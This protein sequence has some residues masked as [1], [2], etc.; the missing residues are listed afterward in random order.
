M[1]A[2]I[3][4]HGWTPQIGE[5]R[6]RG[7]VWM[8]IGRSS[9]QDSQFLVLVQVHGYA[10]RKWA[11]F[12]CGGSRSLAVVVIGTMH[13]ISPRLFWRR[14]QLT[15]PFSSTGGYIVVALAM[16]SNDVFYQGLDVC[17]LLSASMV[18]ADFGLW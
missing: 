16:Y 12:L 6:D 7:N 8:D 5:I 4:D 15:P 9:R 14:S 10:L 18:V 17:M 1:D 3:G 11:L 2:A 13:G